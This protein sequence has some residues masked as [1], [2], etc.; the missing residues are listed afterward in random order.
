MDFDFLG[1]KLDR[2]K[3]VADLL[4]RVR[5]HQ[6]EYVIDRLQQKLE[7]GTCSTIYTGSRAEQITY[8]IRDPDGKTQT[9]N[10]LDYWVE[11]SPDFLAWLEDLSRTPQ[12]V[13]QPQRAGPPTPTVVTI[14]PPAP[15]LRTRSKEPLSKSAK[16]DQQ[17]LKELYD[18]EGWLLDHAPIPPEKMQAW[19]EQRLIQVVSTLM[20]L[21]VLLMPQG[22]RVACASVHDEKSIASRV[23]RLYENLYLEKMGWVET[24]VPAD[25]LELS[26]FGDLRAAKMSS[27]VVLF[28]GAVLT[29]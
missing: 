17:W 20:G 18:H 22:R 10:Y 4:E 26:G 3:Y 14:T 16:T 15:T 19:K 13:H 29:A 25:L 1:G 28:K 9:R 24:R 21:V 27:G 5:P 23:N 6:Y 12:L 7:E 11:C 2:R 8:T